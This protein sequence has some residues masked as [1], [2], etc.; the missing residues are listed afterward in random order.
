MLTSNAQTPKNAESAPDTK[1]FVVEQL[2]IKA[3]RDSKYIYRMED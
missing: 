3:Q 1:R 2:F